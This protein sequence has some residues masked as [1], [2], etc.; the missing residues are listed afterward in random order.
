MRIQR[1][2]HGG[3]EMHKIP[4]PLKQRSATS[5]EYW[6]SFDPGQSIAEIALA[7]CKMESQNR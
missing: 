5:F 2:L 1:W 7:F 6:H 4:S 3:S